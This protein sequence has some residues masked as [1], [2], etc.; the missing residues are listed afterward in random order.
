MEDALDAERQPQSHPPIVDPVLLVSIST[1]KREAEFCCSFQEL[2]DLLELVPPTANL[3]HAYSLDRQVFYTL[4]QLEYWER[5]DPHQF[6][7]IWQ[8]ACTYEL[9]NLLT[10]MVLRADLELVD[11]PAA[12]I[13]IGDFGLRRLLYYAKLEADLGQRRE[14]ASSTYKG[15][16]PNLIGGEFTWDIGSTIR[17]WTQDGAFRAWKNGL[18]Q[19]HAPVKDKGWLTSLVEDAKRRQ[20]AAQC[21]DRHPAAY[22]GTAYCASDRVWQKSQASNPEGMPLFDG[23]AECEL[24]QSELASHTNQMRVEFPNLE[25]WTLS[26]GPASQLGD[27][28]YLGQWDHLF[29]RKDEEPLPSWDALLWI[30]KDHPIGITPPTGLLSNRRYKDTHITSLVAPPSILCDSR[31]CASSLRRYPWKLDQKL[32]DIWYN[33]CL[34]EG[35]FDSPSNYYFWFKKFAEAHKYHRDPVCFRQ[36]VF[37]AVCA[38]WCT[39]Y[40]RTQFNKRLKETLRARISINIF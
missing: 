37:A 21:L 7:A 28:F 13:P 30:G 15:V 9:E 19:L 39:Q 3:E 11:K 32:D 34:M 16:H 29:A 36:A 4:F 31:F 23:A 10:E 40:V 6:E 14:L 24:K 38:Y 26:S 25:N 22:V 17:F 12:Y 5:L 8:A 35:E 2:K 20:M 27:D 18:E 33:F 1:L